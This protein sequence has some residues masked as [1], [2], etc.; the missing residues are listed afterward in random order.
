MDIWRA[1]EL[2]WGASGFWDEQE[3]GEWTPNKLGSEPFSVFKLGKF[4]F[5]LFY[6]YH[7]LTSKKKVRDI[8]IETIPSLFL[9][10]IIFLEFVGRNKW[11]ITMSKI[12]HKVY[13]FKIIKV[14]QV[15]YLYNWE[16]IFGYFGYIA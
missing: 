9:E 8:L 5:Y 16:V 1:L 15:M 4:Y 3:S 13:I 12:I 2:Y 14:I 7:S 10:N 11:N 6:M